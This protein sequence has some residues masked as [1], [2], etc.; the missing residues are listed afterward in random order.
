MC[1]YLWGHF[2]SILDARD[3][4]LH[5]KEDTGKIW[6]L[7]REEWSGQSWVCTS[8]QRR[9]WGCVARWR[10]IRDN[11]EDRLEAWRVVIWRSKK[12]WFMCPQRVKTGLMD[13]QFSHVS[14]KHLL[15]TSFV[16][17]TVLSAGK[18]R[19]WRWMGHTYLFNIRKNFLKVRAVQNGT[20]FWTCSDLPI[21]GACGRRLD[22]HLEYARMSLLSSQ[23]D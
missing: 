20:D 23:W 21:L 15:S 17:S 11:V 22:V 10:S 16:P 12:A 1:C 7:S 13:G 6:S 4:F 8:S 3:L 18:G 19:I 9:K 2:W 5:F 14:H